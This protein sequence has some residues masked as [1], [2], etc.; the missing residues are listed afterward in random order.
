MADDPRPPLGQ[1]SKGWRANSPNAQAGR[2]PGAGPGVHSPDR[3]LK[4][5]F[6][7]VAM[8]A[9]AGVL[10]AWPLFLRPARPPFFLTIPITEYSELTLPANSLAEQDSDALLRHFPDRAAKVF[11]CQERHLLM[12]ELDD[13]P[14]RG[15]SAVVVHLRAHAVSKDGDVFLLP[16][17]ADLG[18]PN[19]WLSL[20]DV[21]RSIRKCP[22]RHRLLLLDV[23]RPIA[24]APLGVLADD[25]AGQVH[26]L[27]E[28]DDGDRLLILCACGPGQVSFVSEDMQQSVFGYYLS[29]G[30][31]GR[32]DGCNP[33]GNRDGRVSVNELVAYVQERV[34]AWARI[35]RNARQTPVF[36]QMGLPRGD[37][38][39]LVVLSRQPEAR[40]LETADTVKPLPAWLRDGWKVRDG[41][42]DDESFRIAPRVFRRLEATLLRAE[43]RW[44]GGIPAELVRRDLETDLRRFRDQ[45]QKARAVPQP[46]PRSLALAATMGLKPDDAVTDAVRALLTKLDNVAKPEEMDGPRKQFLGKFKDKP[47]AVVWAAFELAVAD[48]KPG[49]IEFLN[50]LLQASPSRPQF[51]ETLFLDRLARFKAEHKL[52]DK[53]W[54]RDAVRR[55]LQVVREA[56]QVAAGD[57]RALP[58]A[59]DQI[60]QAMARRHEAE[61]PLFA[62][63]SALWAQAA[64]ELDRVEA[65]FKQINRSLAIL[66]EA[67]RVY[68]E[69]MVLLPGYV[70]CLLDRREFDARDQASWNQAV[71][72][73]RELARLLA[74]PD[75]QA[76]RDIDDQSS[77]LRGRLESLGRS[78]TPRGIKDL[79]AKA[80]RG[81]AR[82]YLDI[83]AVLKSPRLT[84][85]EREALWLAARK[86]AWRLHTDAL[87][88]EPT[89]E[90]ARQPTVGPGTFD[91]EQAGLTERGRAALR[92]R[93][94]LDLFLLAGLAGYE[95]LDRE[96]KEAQADPTGQAWPSLAAK[97]REAW[98]E[99]LPRQFRDERDLAAADRL[100]RLLHP[101]QRHSGD[102]NRNPTAQLRREE[103]Q[104]RWKWLAEYYE[105]EGNRA[106]DQPGYR[107]FYLK[108]AEDYRLYSH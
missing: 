68:D 63:S 12:K 66:R 90:Q 19:T 91:R 77:I 56:E 57:P 88:N 21:L 76:L 87:A 2:S 50:G 18:D 41:W 3:R 72:S 97:L 95:K 27:L 53:K 64:S 108:A 70:A 1:R 102:E 36:W 22:A 60:R 104:A 84:A 51:V 83:E 100:G 16:G 96:L 46:R 25:V 58:W 107:D 59:R 20:R 92:A 61:K 42:W 49:W 17:N 30:L 71:A 4:I 24:A 85:A 37:D 28:K 69:A 5:F 44:R 7:L 23:M 89:G 15:D 67:Q 74:K 9:L 38:F 26:A 14:N 79:V 86:L 39:E 73:A 105:S 35:N 99:R 54:P 43:Q 103:A 13:L 82:N 33:A 32:A 47:E 45:V 78:F 106:V 31:S 75:Q 55:A 94:S 98:T 93:L 52:D 6:L 80:D 34:D 11:Y 10:L 29:E 65:E 81:D 62:D 40:D 101:L 48:P 8:L